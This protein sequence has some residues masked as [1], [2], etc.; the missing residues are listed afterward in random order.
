MSI[1]EMAWS[2]DELKENNITKVEELEQ[3]LRVYDNENWEN[4]LRAYVTLNLTNGDFRVVL[5]EEEPDPGYNPPDPGRAGIPEGTDVGPVVGS[6]S[7]RMK[8]KD[9]MAAS[10]ELEDLEGSMGEEFIQVLEDLELVMTLELNEDESFLM[11][12]DR[13]SALAAANG[14]MKGLVAI[15]P[16]MLAET[17]GMTEEELNE[18]LKKQGVT[19]DDLLAQMLESMNPED[20][21]EDLE[22]SSAAGIFAY[23]DGKLYLASDE[24]AVSILDV[25]LER[26]ELRIVGVE[27][28]SEA[29]EGMEALYPMVFTRN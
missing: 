23:E 15:M 22:E 20:M 14:M 7:Y 2:E 6:W 16:A 27:E 21:I 4:L 24:G 28:N 5:E 17:Y 29:L 1:S 18:V 26:D 25:E 9:A 8:F 11:G 12:F 10:G 3:I 13:E 19:M